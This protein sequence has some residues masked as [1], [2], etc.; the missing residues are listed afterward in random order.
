MD[1]LCRDP[2]AGESLGFTDQQS[3]VSRDPPGPAAVAQS[4][5]PVPAGGFAVAGSGRASSSTGAV[6][7]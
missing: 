4:P 3:S 1:P 2:G 5:E 6:R 7:A